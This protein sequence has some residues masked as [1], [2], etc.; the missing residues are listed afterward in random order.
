MSKI[1][2][3]IYCVVECMEFTSLAKKTE[4][5]KAKT[6]IEVNKLNIR[7]RC[8]VGSGENNEVLRILVF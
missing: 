1:K 2:E 8:N 5:V 6:F 4:I 7:I 3:D